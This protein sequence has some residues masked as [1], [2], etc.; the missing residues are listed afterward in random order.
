MKRT[1]TQLALL[2]VSHTIL[3]QQILNLDFEKPSLDSKV[4][5][6]WSTEN[7]SL[8][9][10]SLD[11]QIKKSGHVSMKVFSER[12]EESQQLSFSL[13]PFDLRGHRISLTGWVKTEN[14]NGSA[15]ISLEY[16]PS[17]TESNVR[18]IDSSSPLITG[19]NN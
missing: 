17:S 5:W 18:S 16:Q 10:T 4:A 6:G 9:A 14:L 1:I 13:E 11:R 12:M 8:I 19:T 2:M 15:Y 7:F 3:G